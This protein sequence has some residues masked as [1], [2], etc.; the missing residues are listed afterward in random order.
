VATQSQIQEHKDKQTRADNG[1]YAQKQEELENA[2]AVHSERKSAWESHD[3]A[4]SGLKRELA[5]AQENKQQADVKMQEKRDEEN[6]SRVKIRDLEHGQRQWIDSYPHA[7]K[8][9]LGAIEKESGFRETPVG[10]MGRYV[11][12]LKPE[13]GSILEK[14]FGGALNAFVVTSKG[15]HTILSEM[16]KRHNW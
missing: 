1:I 7:L 3:D 14:S 11:E 4:L 8:T 9:L 2:K 6:A 12:L 5:D 10:P 13:W 15:D 16:M